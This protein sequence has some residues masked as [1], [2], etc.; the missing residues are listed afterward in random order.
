MESSTCVRHGYYLLLTLFAHSA[1]YKIFD[2]LCTG[3][4][5]TF[6]EMKADVDEAKQI[7]TLTFPKSESPSELPDDPALN[8]NLKRY[9]KLN[10]EGKI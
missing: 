8:K 2:S 1:L 5:P 6:E 3:C 4:R 10:G 9:D 7:N